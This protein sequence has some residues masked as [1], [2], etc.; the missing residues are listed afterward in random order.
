MV[1]IFRS[2]MV[3][4][5]GVAA[6]AFFSS[7]GGGSGASDETSGK[8]QVVAT[9]TMVGDMVRV[10]GGDAVDLTVLMGPGVDPHLYKARPSDAAAIT[11]A[12]L[13]FY[14]GLMLEGQL[15]D[16]FNKASQ[17]GKAV[18]A[19]AEVVDQKELMADPEAENHPDPHVWGDVALW[20]QSLALVIDELVRALPEQADAI[21]E[22][23]A[24]YDNELEQLDA[25]AAA[26]MAE[27]PE[28]HRLLVTSHDAF[29][30]FGRA[31]GFEVV[32]IQGISTA[33]QAGMADVANTV[34]L[35][36]SR[37][38][39]AIFTENSVAPGLIES[40][41]RDAG[42][43]VGGEL[44]SD[45]TGA[46]GVVETAHGESYDVS[47]YIGMIKHNVNTIVDNLK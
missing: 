18:V 23:G 28:E 22:R 42:V 1:S 14:N 5:A 40:V 44:F 34:D 16:L 9:T 2:L 4:V 46:A 35:V 27:V 26:R 12:D 25:W 32:G 45:S 33:T 37:G 19:V 24:A 31:Y 17:R 38:I 41:K 10:V 11:S 43:I 20:R 36:K 47:T 21:R 13:I 6:V 8:L 7:C 29:A 3:L 39:K 30:Y 15:A